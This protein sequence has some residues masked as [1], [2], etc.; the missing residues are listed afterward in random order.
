MDV[1]KL[2]EAHVATYKLPSDAVAFANFPTAYGPVTVRDA[3]F[4]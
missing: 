3:Q 4:A 1:N 2:Q